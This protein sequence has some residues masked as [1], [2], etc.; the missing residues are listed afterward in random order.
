MQSAG[1]IPLNSLQMK[2]LQHIALFPRIQ[3]LSPNLP[4][5]ILAL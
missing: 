2:D 5:A 3:D 4:I 1:K